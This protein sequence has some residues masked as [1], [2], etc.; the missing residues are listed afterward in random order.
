MTQETACTSTGLSLGATLLLTLAIA[1][2]ATA[3]EGSSNS[4]APGTGFGPETVKN[5]NN[6]EPVK[7]GKTAQNL[8]AEKLLSNVHRFRLRNFRALN[9]YYIYTT[10]PEEELATRISDHMD[11]SRQLLEQIKDQTGS[12]LTDSQM[13]DLKKAFNNF[14][15]Q[16]ET[17]IEDVR[18]SGYPD[19]RLLS[20]MANQAQSLSV[21][22]KKIYNQVAGQ[23]AT[24]T[25]T[26]LELAREASITMALMVT[27]YSARSSSSVAQVFQGADSEKS[28][29]DLARSFE[30]TLDKLRNRTEDDGKIDA[31]LS[32]VNSK[33]SFIRGSYIE[34]D[35]QN[36]AFVINRYSTSIIESLEQTI[37]RLK[38]A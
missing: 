6:D 3:Q 35:E 22:S 16:M 38:S 15:D 24:P 12:S 9:D 1:I 26:D 34:Y 33:W 2:P 17:N 20:D 5:D 25:E 23:D 36:V 28:L 31:N 37:D 10:D 7:Q 21:L 19:L 14:D 8:R 13:G 4:G 18:E 27:R 30:N 32:D 11:Q 29:D